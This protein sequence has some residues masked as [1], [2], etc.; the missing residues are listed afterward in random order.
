MDAHNLKF[1]TSQVLRKGPRAGAEAVLTQPPGSR[2]S[3]R[4]PAAGERLLSVHP[5]FDVYI[6]AGLR[7]EANNRVSNALATRI[8]TPLL[9]MHR[10]IGEGCPFV[11]LLCTVTAFVPF[12]SSGFLLVVLHS[13]RCPCV[14]L[15]RDSRRRSLLPRAVFCSAI[16][17]F[18]ATTKYALLANYTRRR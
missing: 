11:C 6:W 14:A 15:A 1:A 16:R 10:L 17:C 8:G 12:S 7:R 9:R 4:G 2:P 3:G 18:F 13:R 5:V